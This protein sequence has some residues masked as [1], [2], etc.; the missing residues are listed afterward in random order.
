VTP[1]DFYCDL[2]ERGA[3][4]VT[5]V[6]ETGDVLAFEHTRP[7]YEH[8]VVVVPKAHVADLLAADDRTL[9]SVLA[10]VRRQA[11]AM[12]ERT[13]ACRVITNLGE[14]QDS[15]H[16]HWHIVSGERTPPA[17]TPAT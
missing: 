4:G 17:S 12:L 8:H 11:T 3:D 1:D 5:V 7:A 13:G 10:I 15:K 14:Y 6:D 9:H 2:L 16:L